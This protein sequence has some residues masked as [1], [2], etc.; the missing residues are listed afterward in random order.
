MLP[1]ELTWSTAECMSACTVYSIYVLRIHHKVRRYILRFKG[2]VS[3]ISLKY[4]TEKTNKKSQN[5]FC[6]FI[7]GQG[8]VFFFFQKRIENLLTLSL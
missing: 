2:A 4:A 6:L 7:W 8:I 1:Y 3:S 5:R